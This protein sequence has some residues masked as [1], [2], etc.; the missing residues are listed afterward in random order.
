MKI[1]QISDSHI[2]HD[3]PQRTTDLEACVSAVNTESPELVIHT[4]DIV[5]NGREDEYRDAKE[6]L[7]QLQAPYLVLAGNKDKRSLINDVF[8]Q[9]L[10]NELCQNHC[11]DFIQYR[12]KTHTANL[13]VLD[14]I[15]EETS[16]GELCRQRLGHLHEMLQDKQPTYIFMHHS[17]FVVEEIPD[18]KQFHHWEHVEAFESIVVRHTQVKAIYC[19]HVHRNVE[20]FAGRL[21]VHVLTCIATDLRKGRLNDSD[22][23]RP[24]YRVIDL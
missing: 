11:R 24:M 6:H 10:H 4:G 2:A 7:D 8:K 15:R 16:K 13:L 9:K 3:T 18:P 22:K 14:T 23:S 5:H 17:P 12:V 20:G 19:G 21:P 1:I